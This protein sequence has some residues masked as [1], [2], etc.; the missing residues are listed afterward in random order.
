MELL[1]HVDEK[2]NVIGSI[3]RGRAHKTEA[4]HRSGMIF[5]LDKHDNILI[6]HRSPSKETFP[7]CYDASSTFHITFGETYDQGANRELFEET[8]LKA[9]IKFMGKFLHH[10][11]PEYQMVAVYFCRSD[12]PVVL[13]P[14]EASEARFLSRSQVDRIIQ[15][16]KTTPWLRDW[17]KVFS[18]Y[19]RGES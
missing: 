15:Q 7:D 5:L 18:K 12:K 16:E 10:D 6:Q 2:D 4:L 19:M 8:G 1:Y 17:W 14:N 3:E 13:D 11:S 9:K